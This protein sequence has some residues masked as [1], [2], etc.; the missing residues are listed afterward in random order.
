MVLNKTNAKMLKKLF[1]PNSDNPADAVGHKV[2]LKVEKVKA[3]GETVDA[4]RI[5]EY[6]EIKC[7]D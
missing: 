3:F 4:I 2:I 6:S 7:A 5:R 1:S